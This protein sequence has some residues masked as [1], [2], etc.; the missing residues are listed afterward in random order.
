MAKLSCGKRQAEKQARKDN[1]NK[2]C[3]LCY[4]HSTDQPDDSYFASKYTAA[5]RVVVINPVVDN[6]LRV[7]GP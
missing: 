1:A 2:S 5:S 4:P 3:P 6:E 7:I